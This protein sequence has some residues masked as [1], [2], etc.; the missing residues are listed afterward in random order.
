MKVADLVLRL[1]QLRPD[2][3]IIAVDKQGYHHA[4]E[5]LAGGRELYPTI[6]LHLSPGSVP[7]DGVNSH[8]VEPLPPGHTICMTCDGKGITPLVV[9]PESFFP[10]DPACNYPHCGCPFEHPGTEGWCAQ[11]RPAA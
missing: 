8:L 3:S 6:K 4:V 10:D 7:C 2:A 5:S 9:E 1:Q 11:G